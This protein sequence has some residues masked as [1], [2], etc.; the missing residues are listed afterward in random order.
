VRTCLQQK[1]L[2]FSGRAARS[3]FWW[4]MLFLTIVSIV[5]YSI[6]GWLAYATSTDSSMSILGV[7]VLGVAA[8]VELALAPPAIAAAVRRLHDLGWSGWWYLAQLIPVVGGVV[9]LVMFV[10]FL[11]RGT[12]GSNKYGPDP[13]GGV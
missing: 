1:Y 6:A 5:V 12:V 3:E 9:A 13:L 11:M 2:G 4:F 8:L 7:V 10:G